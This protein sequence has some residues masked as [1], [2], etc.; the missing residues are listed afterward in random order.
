MKRLFAA[1]V[2]FALFAGL[3]LAQEPLSLPSGTS[4]KMKL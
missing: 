1:T 3:A 4:V 2:V